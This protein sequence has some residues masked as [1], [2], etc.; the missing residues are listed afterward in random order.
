MSKAKQTSGKKDREKTKQ[1]KRR[2]KEE[3][4][5]E[6]K[7]NSK[8]GQG[9]GSMIAYVDAYGQL[10]DTPPDNSLKKEIKLEQIQIDIPKQ[11]PPDPA[12]RVRTGVVTFFNTAK[13]FGFIKDD[14][15]GE[16]FFVHVNSI[17]EPITENDKVMFEIGKG[18]KGPAAMHV[19]K[20]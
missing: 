14:K 8:K 17:E 13:A 3:R 1:S 19:K 20:A 18:H 11:K 9:L 16:S 4:R 6:R 5:E 2:E 12:E 15:S 10:T 7:N